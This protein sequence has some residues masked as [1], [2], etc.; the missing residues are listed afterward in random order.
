M[1]TETPSTPVSRGSG[2]LGLG[3]F[4]FDHLNHLGSEAKDPSSG[5]PLSGDRRIG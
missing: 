4:R 5:L 3:Q 2:Y 1:G